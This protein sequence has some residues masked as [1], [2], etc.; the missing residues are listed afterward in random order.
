MVLRALG[1]ALVLA[2]GGSGC[3]SPAGAEGAPRAPLGEV[4]VSAQQLQHHPVAI[5]AAAE[6]EIHASITVSGKIA[7]DD[8]KVAHVF[9][10]VT[11]RVTAILAQPGQRVKRGDALARIS[12]PEVG[13]AYADVVK[14]QADL[15]ATEHEWQRQ[16]LLVKDHAGSRRDYENAEDNYR[17]AN[18]ELRRAQ[19]KTHLLRSGSVNQVTQEYTLRAPIDGDVVARTNVNMGTE[20]TGQYGIGNAIELFTIGVLDRVWVVGD[21]FEADLPRVRR[22]E[23]VTVSVISYPDTPFV[24]EVEWVAGALDPQSRTAKV[25]CSVA[26]PRRELKPEMAATIAI[27]APGTNYLAV[28]RDAIVRLGDATVVFIEAGE[29]PSGQRRFE[30]RPVTLLD[31]ETDPFVAVTHGL[32]AGDRIVSS[33]ASTLAAVM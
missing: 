17:K 12:S 8:L 1:L 10:P 13:S 25:R 30:R 11:G 31:D 24:G 32:T 15:T 5:T 28:P 14:A 23:P 6:H 22:G 26:N 16:Q 29:T 7:F 19:Q 27:A 2:L 4:W 21:V 9:S 18:A 3:A 33:G 20:V